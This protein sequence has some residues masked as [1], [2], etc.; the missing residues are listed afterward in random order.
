MIKTLDK[1]VRSAKDAGE[2]K[3]D[4]LYR[5]AQSAIHKAAKKN[6]IHKNAAARKISSLSRYVN[7]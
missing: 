5:D 3:V 7:A 6:V 1:K 4:D 2:D